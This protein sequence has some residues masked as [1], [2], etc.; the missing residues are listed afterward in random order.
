[1][2][3]VHGW[4]G[5]MWSPVAACWSRARRC[6]GPRSPPTTRGC[7]ASPVALA[8]TTSTSCITARMTAAGRCSTMKTAATASNVRSVFPPTP[9][10]PT[11]WC[12]RPAGPMW[13]SAGIR[14]PT[15]AAPCC[16]MQR[17]IRP[18]SSTSRARGC[19]SVCSSWVR[20][21]AARSSTSSRPP[22]VSSACW[23]KPFLAKWSACCRPPVTMRASW[24]R[25]TQEKIP[26]TG[27][28]SIRPP[29]K[30]RS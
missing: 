30:R 12:S 13:W 8:K 23:K 29:A 25:S 24:S 2:T 7:C 5:W 14:R 18:T 22:R 6:S 4:N 28:C 21:R 10:W 11:W 1:M 20:R 9:S 26:A 3:P 15:S 16:R 19:R 17:S 27:S